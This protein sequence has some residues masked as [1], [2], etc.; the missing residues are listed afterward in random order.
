MGD[1]NY[2]SGVVKVLENP[3]Q[4]LVNHKIAIATFRVKIAQNRGNKIVPL[5]VWGNLASQVQHYYQKNDYILIEGYLSIRKKRTRMGKVDNF[6][7][8]T[9]TALKIYPFFLQ[10]KTGL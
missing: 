1:T 3:K 4:T 9:L 2:F 5:V 8:T 6:Q 7:K 10:S